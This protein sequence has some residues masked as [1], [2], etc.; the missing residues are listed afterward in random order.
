MDAGLLESDIV[1]KW[2]GV[3]SDEDSDEDIETYFVFESDGA[4]TIYLENDD[5]SREKYTGSWHREGPS[6]FKVVCARY[7]VSSEASEGLPHDSGDM[8]WIE[9]PVSTTYWNKSWSSLGEFESVGMF[10]KM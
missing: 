5:E 2:R 1:G 3:R 9:S 7:F 10:R 8:V 4:L 6:G